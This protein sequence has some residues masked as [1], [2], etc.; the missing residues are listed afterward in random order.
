[1]PALNVVKSAALDRA[2]FVRPR[3]LNGIELV[4]VSYRHRT[5][6]VHTHDCYVVGTIIAGAEALCVKGRTHVAKTGDTLQLYPDEPHANH[7]V[8]D[9]ALQY[10]VFYLPVASIEAYI[11]EGQSLSFSTPVVSDRSLAQTL[12]ELHVRLSQGPA[13]RLEQE[14][15]LFSLVGALAAR[16]RSD[17]AEARHD[18]FAVRR[19][20]AWIDE[21]F[22]EDVGLAELSAIAEL[23][24]FRFAHLFK[25]STGLSPMAYRNQRRVYEA[26]RLLLTDQPIADIASQLGFADQSH[27]TRQFQR[28]MGISPNRYRQQ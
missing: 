20:R 26:R 10:R 4:S 11:G 21:H 6:P 1:M 19:V 15:A 7:T 8:G 22:A 28:I 27:L 24:V 12:V 25:A 17:S 5:F 9:T 16:S 3:F 2:V 18:N 23:S 14:S 13:R